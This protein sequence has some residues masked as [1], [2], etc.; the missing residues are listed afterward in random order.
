[1]KIE[2][3]KDNKAVIQGLP[4]NPQCVSF[5]LGRGRMYCNEIF[6]ETQGGNS[7]R[8][9]YIDANDGMQFT[10]TT[11]RSRPIDASVKGLVLALHLTDPKVTG[12]A[13]Y[14][15]L[16][17]ALDAAEQAAS[18]LHSFPDGIK[19]SKRLAYHHWVEAV[20][21]VTTKP[22]LRRI[23]GLVLDAS[24]GSSSAGSSW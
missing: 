8:S 17:S 23:S 5:G 7:G 19:V 14:T 16:E 3:N 15:C 21:Q 20:K 6:H 4:Q 12:Q 24:T 9:K 1:M 13:K 10:S 18:G 22:N 2:I 11:Q